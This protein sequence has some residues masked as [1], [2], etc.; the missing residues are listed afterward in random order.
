MAPTS[1]R[2][3]HQAQVQAETR[4][5]PEASLHA[6]SFRPRREGHASHD[7]RPRRERRLECESRG[8]Y[9]KALVLPQSWVG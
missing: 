6:H 7:E 9:S 5:E 1:E 4:T 2:D 3:A 8:L